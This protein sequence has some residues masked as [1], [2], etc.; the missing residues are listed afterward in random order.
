MSV[1]RASIEHKVAP[2]CGE[3]GYKVAVEKFGQALVDALPVYTRGPRKGKP[4]GALCWTK[5]GVGGWSREGGLGHVE[6]P[7]VRDWRITL[8]PNSTYDHGVVAR[9]H[10]E[11][12][13][14]RKGG[15]VEAVQ[16][17]SHA[18]AMFKQHE[19]RARYA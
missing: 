3:W 17:P 4:K 12:Q 18:A 9:W 5:V 11:I 15:F 2:L 7:G 8:S 1:Q 13:D 19:D 16:E 14:G 6:R 10:W